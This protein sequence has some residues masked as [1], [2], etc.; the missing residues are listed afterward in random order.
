MP[1]SLQ[2]WERDTQDARSVSVSIPAIERDAEFRRHLPSH[3][4]T[5]G[6]VHVCRFLAAGRCRILE[7]GWHRLP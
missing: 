2:G 6:L 5:L 7:V 3:A 4:L 1:H